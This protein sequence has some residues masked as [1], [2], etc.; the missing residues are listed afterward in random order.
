[1]YGYNEEGRTTTPFDM[2]VLNNMDRFH[3]AIGAIE[4]AG[5]LHAFGGDII[6]IFKHQLTAHAAYIPNMTR[7]C[8]RWWTGNG[9][10]RNGNGG[11]H[12]RRLNPGDRRAFCR[13]SLE[14]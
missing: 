2:L 14:R 1:M 12:E 6:D 8:P 4:R 3:L 9:A 5:R 10:G 7:T 11:R 13:K